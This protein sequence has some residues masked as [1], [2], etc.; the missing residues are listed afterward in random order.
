MRSVFPSPK[1]V[2]V[3]NV[4]K[5]VSVCVCLSAHREEEEGGS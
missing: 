3:A 4:V 2:S 5:C 1:I